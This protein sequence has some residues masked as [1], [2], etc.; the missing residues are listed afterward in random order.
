MFDFEFVAPGE[1][2]TVLAGGHPGAFGGWLSPVVWVSRLA[3]SASE[4]HG[5]LL[6]AA[7]E[8]SAAPRSMVAESWK[9]ACTSMNLNSI[10]MNHSAPSSGGNIFAGVADGRKKK[11]C[12]HS[13]G[14]NLS[15]IGDNAK[16]RT[17]Q[18]LIAFSMAVEA[19][20]S[21]QGCPKASLEAVQTAAH[22]N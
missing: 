21:S 17:L 20:G 4:Q 22:A 8:G 9:V 6:Q 2:N 5:G 3:W 10:W 11:L 19:W 13:L 14:M 16:S 15:P 12:M 7:T 18:S 1:E